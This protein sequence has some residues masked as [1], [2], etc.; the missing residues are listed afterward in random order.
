M[1]EITGH[2]LWNVPTPA[3]QPT[4]TPIYTHTT[5]VLGQ[6]VLTRT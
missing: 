4:T 6:N 2:R 5:F 3:L 1:E